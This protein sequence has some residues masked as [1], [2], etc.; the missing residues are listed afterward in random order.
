MLYDIV[1]IIEEMVSKFRRKNQ[2]LLCGSRIIE[3]E[4]VT[5]NLGTVRGQ[6]IRILWDTRVM[7]LYWLVWNERNNRIFS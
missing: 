2:I 7:A 5:D 6:E 1:I 4:T 3:N